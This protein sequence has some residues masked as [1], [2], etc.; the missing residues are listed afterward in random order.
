MTTWDY[1]N[2]QVLIEMMR[3]ASNTIYP[4]SVNLPA[5]AIP[6]FERME[7]RFYSALQGWETLQNAIF[8]IEDG[9]ADILDYEHIL[10]GKA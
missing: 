1:E 3:D 9:K 2:Y 8:Q 10:G 6:A 5:Y 4:A 7:Q